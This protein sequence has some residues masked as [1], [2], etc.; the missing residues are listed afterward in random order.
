MYSI[1][2]QSLQI[3]FR[4]ACLCFHT[5][6]RP[7]PWSFHLASCGDVGSVA[8]QNPFCCAAP[9]LFDPQASLA[10]LQGMGTF[11]SACV[12]PPPSFHERN[13]CLSDTI[14]KHNV[15]IDAHQP[16][17]QE[18]ATSSRDPDLRESGTQLHRRPGQ[19]KT[20]NSAPHSCRGSP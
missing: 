15:L 11:T 17:L 1:S 16:G 19:N 13:N 9:P 3:A 2:C 6:D 20:S 10:T 4:L 8:T 7:L 18:Y 5:F 14:I 12:L